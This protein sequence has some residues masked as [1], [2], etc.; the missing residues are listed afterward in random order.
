MPLKRERDQW[1]WVGRGKEAVRMA[2]DCATRARNEGHPDIALK[3]EYWV[4]RC[5]ADPTKELKIPLPQEFVERRIKLPA[6][7]DGP[8][9]WKGL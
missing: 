7:V 1:F 4:R 9:W 6:R 5:M 8:P 3:W 2:N